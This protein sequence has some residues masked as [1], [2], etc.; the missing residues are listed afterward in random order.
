[1]FTVY[2]LRRSLAYCTVFYIFFDSYLYYTVGAH[3]GVTFVLAL[4]SLL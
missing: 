1:M 4:S 3:C 2:G